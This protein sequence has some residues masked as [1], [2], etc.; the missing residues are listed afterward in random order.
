MAAWRLTGR[1][2]QICWDADV[3]SSVLLSENTKEEGIEVQPE[4]LIVR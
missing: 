1:S 2:D 4:I 3:F